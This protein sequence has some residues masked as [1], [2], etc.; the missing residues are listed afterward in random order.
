MG[1]LPPADSGA[2]LAAVLSAVKSDAELRDLAKVL[3]AEAKRHNSATAAAAFAEGASLP[4][5]A[6]N[7]PACFD[8]PKERYRVKCLLATQEAP[9][10]TRERR[11]R[12][13]VH[14]FVR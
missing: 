7:C 2:M 9:G 14:I 11:S 5:V 10:G 3:R 8:A 12:A 13:T 4:I 1:S 6:E